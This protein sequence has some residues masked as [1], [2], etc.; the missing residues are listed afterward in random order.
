M[1]MHQVAIAVRSDAAAEHNDFAR[2]I[3]AYSMQ[4]IA[5]GTRMFVCEGWKAVRSKATTADDCL[6]FYPEVSCRKSITC[7]YCTE[8]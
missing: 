1:S 8:H 5:D 4:I 3:V 6:Q 7:K 2:F